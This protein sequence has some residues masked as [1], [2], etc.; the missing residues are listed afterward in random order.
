M[1]LYTTRTTIS[2]RRSRRDLAFGFE[3]CHPAHGAGDADP[4]TL[5]CRVARHAAFHHCPHNAFAKIAGKRHPRRPL[6]RRQS[7]SRSKPIWRIPPT[8]QFAGDRSS[9]AQKLNNRCGQNARIRWVRRTTGQKRL[10]VLERSGTSPSEPKATEPAIGQIEVDLVAQPTLRANAEA[11]ADDQHAPHQLGIDR[12]A[13]RLAVVRPQTRPQSAQID[14][15][16]DLGLSHCHAA[17][18]KSRRLR[19]CQA[20]ATAVRHVVIAAAR[21]TRCVWA[22]VRWRWTLKV[23]WTAACVE[24]NFWAEPGLL[25]RCILRSRRRVG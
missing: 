25:N 11:V 13:T 17:S 16:V 3:A 10:A 18:A 1:G 23:L 21:S 12:R 8:I 14:E 6:A 24:R 19:N 22:E 2:P 4:K 9:V 5:G 7:S 20:T 15:A